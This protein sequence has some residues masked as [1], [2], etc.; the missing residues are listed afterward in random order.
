MIRPL[1]Q[2]DIS[3]IVRQEEQVF[4]YTLGSDHYIQGFELGATFGFVVDKEGIQA[5]LLCW[6]NDRFVQIDNLYV[7]ST[8][9]KQGLGKK[10]LTELF[11]EL[12]RRG[13]TE[14]S[15]EVATVNTVAIHLYESMG[16]TITQTLHHYLPDRSDAYRM[17]Y[18]KE[19]K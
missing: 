3:T 19:S 16:F 8:S 1:T 5:A 11:D 13:I 12:Q 6:Q 10:L 7:L 18:R 15:L 4:G 14:A 17:I 9:R 2:R